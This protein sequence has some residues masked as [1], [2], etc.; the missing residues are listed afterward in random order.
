MLAPT[1]IAVFSGALVFALARLRFVRFT[2]YAH[3]PG[4]ATSLLLGYIRLMV[5]LIRRDTSRHFRTYL[6]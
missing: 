5:K 4:P 3:L 2:Q 1:V 6:D